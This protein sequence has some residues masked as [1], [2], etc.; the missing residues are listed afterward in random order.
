MLLDKPIRRHQFFSKWSTGQVVTSSTMN[1]VA[2][3][4]HTALDSGVSELV[5]VVLLLGVYKGVYGLSSRCVRMVLLRGLD[6]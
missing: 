1:K 5:V 2:G 6:E 3:V 4:L